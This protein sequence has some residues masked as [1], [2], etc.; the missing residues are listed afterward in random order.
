VPAAAGANGK[1][2]AQPTTFLASQNPD[3]VKRNVL[4][5]FKD[6]LLLP[7][8]IIP[9]TA[10]YVVTAGSTA[11]VSGFSMLNPN[12]WTGS[13][14]V[15]PAAASAV[16]TGSGA[17]IKSSEKVDNAMVFELGDDDDEA[18]TTTREGLLRRGLHSPSLH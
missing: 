1:A 13:G 2:A 9:R 17:Y 12:K 11:A 8:T 10:V 4:S 18:L 5:S 3:Q 15:T 14:T 7:V 16:A 6:A